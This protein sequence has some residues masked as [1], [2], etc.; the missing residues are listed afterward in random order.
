MI[1]GNVIDRAYAHWTWAGNLIAMTAAVRILIP[2]I[3]GSGKTR[4]VDRIP[5][6]LLK[7]RFPFNVHIH[8]TSSVHQSILVHCVHRSIRKQIALR[9]HIVVQNHRL[10]ILVRIEQTLCPVS[11]AA[12]VRRKVLQIR[13]K[14][15]SFLFQVHSVREGRHR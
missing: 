12:L 6:V 10:V 13:Y 4:I 9:V 7:V 2:H 15:V 14:K 8:L 5:I 11:P 3:H 1:R